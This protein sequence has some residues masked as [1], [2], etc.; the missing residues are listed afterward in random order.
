[1]HRHLPAVADEVP[2]EDVGV[3]HPAHG[4]VQDVGL[5]TLTVRAGSP[6][7]IVV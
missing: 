6:T 5:G 2:A 7:R 3:E 1:L 4:V